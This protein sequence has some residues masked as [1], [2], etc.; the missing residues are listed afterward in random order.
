MYYIAANDKN[1]IKQ[2]YENIY[3]VGKYSDLWF[4]PDGKPLITVMASTTWDQNDATEKAISE[5]FDFRLR[6]WPTESF[7]REGWPW[8]EFEYPQPLHTDAVNVSVA[9]HTSVKMSERT[10]NRGRGF[11]LSTMK[12]DPSKVAE[13]ANLSLIHI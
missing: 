11:D 2:L 12:N 1:C 9:Q 10:A 5:F 13:G 3:S 6:Q 8:I 7:L 4:A